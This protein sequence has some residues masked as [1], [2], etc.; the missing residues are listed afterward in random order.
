MYIAGYYTHGTYGYTPLVDYSIFWGRQA[1]AWYS[2]SPPTSS[3]DFP[4]LHEQLLE[5]QH[6][7]VVVAQAVAAAPHLGLLRCRVHALLGD[8][9]AD[10]PRGPSSRRVVEGDHVA[11][12]GA[13]QSE[14]RTL[15]VE[16][17]PVLCDR[18]AVRLRRTSLLQA[19]LPAGGV[20]A[21]GR[22]VEGLLERLPLEPLRDGRVALRVLPRVRHDLRVAGRLRLG[23]DIRAR[24]RGHLGEGAARGQSRQHEGDEGQSIGRRHGRSPDSSW[25]HGM[26]SPGR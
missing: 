6:A 12:V 3:I 18:V 15:H 16:Q 5:A 9:V 26:N 1:A 21:V 19:L 14:G 24:V 10:A 8:A 20:V 23:G 25:V 4:L 7:L 17:V 13:H 11:R 22:G 2:T